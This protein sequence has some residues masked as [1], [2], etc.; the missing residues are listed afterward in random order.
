MPCVL[1]MISST[2]LN[3]GQDGLSPVTNVYPALFKFTGSIHRVVIELI[4]Y[5]QG[6][7]KEATQTVFKSKM[8]Q[9]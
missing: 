3:S 7:E 1:R 8:P 9:Q 5:I 6:Q 4:K 2:G